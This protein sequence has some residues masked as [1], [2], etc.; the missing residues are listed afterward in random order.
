MNTKELHYITYDP[1]EIWSEMITAYVD[2]GGD[3]LYPG[4]EKEIL[5]R[6]MQ[7]IVTQVFAGVDNAL[8]MM[9][10]RYAVDDY[11]DVIGEQRNCPRITAQ[12]AKAMV[13]ITFKATGQSKTLK[14]G[15]AMTA[16]GMVFYALT[17]DVVQTG[18]V[19][20]V[21]TLVAC[22]MAGSS[23]NGLLA[24]T[25][26]QFTTINTAVVSIVVTQD[27]S[28]GND[29]EENDTYRER[30]RTFGLSSVTTGP[31][32]QYESV[33]MSVSSEIL[34][35]K[36]I[37]LGAGNVGVYL[38]LQNGEGS[39][40][41]IEAVKAALSPDDVRPLNDNVSV[42]QADEAFYALDVKY[43]TDPGSNAA[44]ALEAAVATYQEWQDNKIGRAFN[45]DRLM[46]LL[47]N[48]GAIWV[49]W[50]EGSHFRNGV[51]QYTQLNENVR[52]KGTI[53][54]A[55]IDA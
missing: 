48:A 20:V 1:N 14:A 44:E 10:L 51:V 18:N 16:D 2:A 40:A 49:A 22:T 11:L 39:N 42:L 43:A 38:I 32:S 9:T 26:M 33:A 19:Q 21:N 7:A 29:K 6:G 35:A 34:D 47:Y 45:P 37:N 15:T 36:A 13:Q 8:R 23:G 30:I 17:A 54:L 28:G 55:V 46:A 12:A 27:A 3:I 24:G 53:T 31:A 50:G 4:D 25:Q 5:L 52:C 41:I